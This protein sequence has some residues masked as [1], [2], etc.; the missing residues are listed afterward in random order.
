MKI[1]AVLGSPRSKSNSTALARTILDKA[2]ELGSE[3]EEFVLNKLSFKGCQACET[4]KKKLDRCV[5]NDELTQVLDA[6]KHADAV[7]LASP[8]YFGEVSAQFKAFFD[9]TYSYLN[10]DFSSRV[11]P[12]KA[13]VFIYAQG[14]SGL[15]LY[16]DVYP[17]YEFWLKRYG[18]SNNRLIRMNGPRDADSIEKRPDL[19][20]QAQDVAKSL[21]S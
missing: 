14:Q 19:I 11:Q 1:V 4:C 15:E 18:F 10:P 5:L 20:E 9:R 16:A 2:R 21:V 13:S 12:G 7:I 8:N 17:R 6:V 3:T